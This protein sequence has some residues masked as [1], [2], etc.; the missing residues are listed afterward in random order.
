MKRT[1]NPMLRLISRKYL[2]FSFCEKEIELKKIMNWLFLY[3]VL[4]C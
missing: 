4:I 1:D 2:S 3:L